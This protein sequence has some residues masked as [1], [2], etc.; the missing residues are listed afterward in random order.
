MKNDKRKGKGH[1][2]STQTPARLAVNIVNV[3]NIGKTTMLRRVDATQ[4]VLVRASACLVRPAARSSAAPHTLYREK[5][6]AP[7]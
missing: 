2:I 4:A 7:T 1:E 6:R 3:V 5:F